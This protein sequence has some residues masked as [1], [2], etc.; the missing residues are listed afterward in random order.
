MSLAFFFSSSF[1]LNFIYLHI[2]LGLTTNLCVASFTNIVHIR[3][4]RCTDFT[5]QRIRDG[6]IARSSRTVI[7]FAFQQTIGYWDIDNITLWDYQ[8]NQNIFRNGDFESGS[9]SPDYTQCQSV[10]YISNSSEFDGRYCYSDRT[11]GQ[12]GYLM[13]NVSTTV[14]SYHFLEFYLQNR[15][16][17]GSSYMVLLGT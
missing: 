14:G 9:L 3:S 16:G 12:F 2:F 5:Y 10:G 1:N 13:Q 7:I 8:A 6:F 17:S 11:S 4:S 15:N